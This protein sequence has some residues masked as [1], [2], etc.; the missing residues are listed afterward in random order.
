MLS[1]SRPLLMWSNAFQIFSS[2][3]GDPYKFRAMAQPKH[4]PDKGRYRAET[5]NNQCSALLR[6]NVQE[7]INELVTTTL[8]CDSH[9]AEGMGTAGALLPTLLGF[10]ASLLHQGNGSQSVACSRSGTWKLVR[11]VNAPAPPQNCWNSVLPSPL[12]DSD[13]C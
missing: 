7:A 8:L 4:L 3:P 6:K 11:K 5:C 13:V 9:G 10:P 12:A 1:L 2:L